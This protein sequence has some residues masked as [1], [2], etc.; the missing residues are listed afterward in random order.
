MVS[1][2]QVGADR[3]H[4]EDNEDLFK[5]GLPSG[6]DLLVI[7]RVKNSGGRVASAL[8]GDLALYLR[9][10]PAIESMVG[11]NYSIVGPTYVV[12]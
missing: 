9:D 1:G 4:V 3:T 7:P 6:N 5:L 8:F 2:H 10:G 11:R 12:N